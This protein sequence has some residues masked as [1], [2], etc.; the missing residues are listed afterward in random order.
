MEAIE[1][2]SKKTYEFDMIFKQLY[3]LSVTEQHLN[4]TVSKIHL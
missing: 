4:L 3:R 1:Q 2:R